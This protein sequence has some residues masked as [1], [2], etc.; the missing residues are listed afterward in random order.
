MVLRN[1]LTLEPIPGFRMRFAM[2]G[3]GERAALRSGELARLA[4]VSA[5]TL[6]HYE[7]KGVLP[8]P[9]RSRAGYREYPPEALERVR[10]GRGALA[11]GFTLDELAGV[12]RARDRGA[13][14]CAR[15]RSL[16][17]EKLASVE[18][19]LRELASVRDT[20]R[21]LI[22]EWDARL[23]SAGDGRPARLLDSLA[24]REA[25]AGAARGDL[26]PR[27]TKGGIDDA[28]ENR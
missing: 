28:N 2:K 18:E 10:L 3:N 14:P 7:R 23:A 17:D 4:G 8:A 9:R 25:T 21:A 6:R 5:D 22:A 13:A 24:A 1:G 27:R 20:L 11:V 12:L 26:R 19:R 16:A 15:V